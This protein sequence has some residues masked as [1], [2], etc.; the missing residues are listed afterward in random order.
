MCKQNQLMRWGFFALL[1]LCMTF[2]VLANAQSTTEGG[3]AGTVFDSTGAV[4]SGATV[5]I[6]ND[7]TDAVFKVTTDASG[8]FKEPLLPAASYTVTVDATG[9]GSFKLTSVITQVGQLTEIEPHIKAGTTTTV[10]VSGEAPILNFESPDISSVLNTRAIE[11]IP[12]N[13][14]RWSDMT[15]LTPGAVADSSGFGLI[16]FR[17]ISPILN[18]VEIDGADDNDAYY[19]EERGRTREGYSTSKYMVQELWTCG[20]RRD[21]RHQQE[22][23]EHAACHDVFF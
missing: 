21:Q 15:L 19:S 16:A 17:G 1:A 3:I 11:D 9:F 22:R 10:E 5:T 13:G 14:G 7:A 12:L 2:G 20:R 6:H 4:V 18:N 23:L 8:Y